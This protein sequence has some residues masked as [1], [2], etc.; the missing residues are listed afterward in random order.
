MV[1]IILKACLWPLPLGIP[2]TSRPLT[3]PERWK[4]IC[5]G[6]L[7]ARKAGT[8]NWP[9]L[10]PEKNLVFRAVSLFRDCTGCNRG[11]RVTVDKRI[12]LGGGLGGGSTDAASTLL[13]LNTLAAPP[14]S[15]QNG[16]LSRDSLVELGASLGS[17]VP[18]FLYKAVTA[19]VSGSGQRIRPF[20]A[21]KTF[22]KLAFVL[23]TPGFSSETAAAYR[24]LDESRAKNSAVPPLQPEIPAESPL[25]ALSGPPEQW[26]FENDFLPLFLDGSLRDS[27]PQTAGSAYRHM[28]SSL[29]EAGAA[30]AGLS[31]S[32]STCFGVF[33]DPAAASDA[34]N[35]LSKPGYATNVT[36]PLAN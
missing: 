3:R 11:L 24:L 26:P 29:R 19:W 22:T 20:E 21:P 2:S 30:F 17:D 7:R 16:P 1:S 15:P 32:G 14:D 9:S 34:E 13:A 8:R 36:F 18:F 33:P 35:F 25:Q 6:V 31:G 4:Y 28:L 10:P 5:G 12:P 27:G 23:V